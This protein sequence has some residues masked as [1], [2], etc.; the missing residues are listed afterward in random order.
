MHDQQEN[1]CTALQCIAMCPNGCEHWQCPQ[2]FGHCGIAK[3][4]QWHMKIRNDFG[5]LPALGHILI[6]A[7]AGKYFLLL[8]MVRTPQRSRAPEDSIML[9]AFCGA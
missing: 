7:T 8:V 4:M 9:N 2:Y 5:Q 3:T 6:I 1:L